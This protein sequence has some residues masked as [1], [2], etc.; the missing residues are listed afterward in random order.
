[1]AQDGN[2]IVGVD[3]LGSVTSYCRSEIVV[4]C[5]RDVNINS[6]QDDASAPSFPKQRESDEKVVIGLDSFR[7]F[8]MSAKTKL[9]SWSAAACSMF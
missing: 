1:M 6:E 2:G 8:R 7:K 5:N 3:K 4:S 9:S